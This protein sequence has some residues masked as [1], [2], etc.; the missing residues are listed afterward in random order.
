MGYYVLHNLVNF[1][2]MQI[3]VLKSKIHRATVTDAC[4]DYPG[5]ITLDEELLQAADILPW[6]KVLI[7]NLTSGSRIESYAIPGP[8]GSGREAGFAPRTASWHH[9]LR[10]EA[11]RAVATRP[12][13]RRA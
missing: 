3:E 10:N 5:S 4:V 13:L 1:A 6:E 9:R 11:T 7:A 12:A 2:H 8:A